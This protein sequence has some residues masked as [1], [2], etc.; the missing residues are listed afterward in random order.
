MMVKSVIWVG[1][2][3]S[4]FWDWVQWQTYGIPVQ[5]LSWKWILPNKTFIVPNTTQASNWRC[6]KCCESRC[7]LCAVCSLTWAQNKWVSSFIFL[8]VKFIILFSFNLNPCVIPCLF[9]SLNV[10][11]NC[12]LLQM[13]STLI[14]HQL[15]LLMTTEFVCASVYLEMW[16]FCVLH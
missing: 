16:G 2:K 12:K 3:R 11:G 10:F 14:K 5:I 1:M 13:L 7:I 8:A 15:G 4:F 6:S 9:C